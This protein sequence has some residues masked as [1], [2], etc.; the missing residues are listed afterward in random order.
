VRFIILLLYVAMLASTTQVM[1]QDN[2]KGQASAYYHFILTSCPGKNLEITLKNGQKLSGKCHTPLAD[3]FRITHK[4]MTHDIPYVS[5][6]KI[7]IRR[8]WFGKLK[9]GVA[10]PYLFIKL[11]LGIEELYKF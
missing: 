9:E 1:A 3:H 4:G 8:G 11:T 2:S 6:E 5:I 10:V 7:D